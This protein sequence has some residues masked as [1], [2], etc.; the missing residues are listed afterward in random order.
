MPI[1]VSYNGGS[2]NGGNSNAPMA[3]LVHP[4]GD[5]SSFV[6][7]LNGSGLL[8][9][10]HLQ[11]LQQLQ[12]VPLLPV[13]S[14]QFSS[15]INANS[16][17]HRNS[18][19]T[20][21]LSQYAYPMWQQQPQQPDVRP[22]STNGVSNGNI[23]VPQALL[24]PSSQFSQLRPPPPQS[25]PLPIYTPQLQQPP[26]QQQQQQQ[27]VMMQQQAAYQR[28]KPFPEPIS[29]YEVE[30]T[31]RMDGE[32]VQFFDKTGLLGYMP[33]QLIGKS[34]FSLID[35]SDVPV[36]DQVLAIAREVD[37]DVTMLFRFQHIGNVPPQKNSK[38]N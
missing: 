19:V 16:A 7:Q 23:N 4:L 5:F 2:S 1:L 21:S 17:F 13:P 35:P 24:R 28:P 26:Q 29:R 34:M 36:L 3:P 10:Q 8:P 11:Q 12:S 27:Q 33:A 6:P 9:L 15:N 38:R 20:P 18:T 31:T 37:N 32:F 14:T 22:L 25:M 30:W